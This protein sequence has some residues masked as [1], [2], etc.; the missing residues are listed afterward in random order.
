M[1]AGGY[2][3]APEWLKLYLRAHGRQLTSIAG[4]SLYALHGGELCL[5]RDGALRHALL[6]QHTQHTH[7]SPHIDPLG[8][9][10]GQNAAAATANAAAGHEEV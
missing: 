1:I 2:E 8:V 6:H 3:A 5:A 7:R 9:V 10:A 4:M